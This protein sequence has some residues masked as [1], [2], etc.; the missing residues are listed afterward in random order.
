[1]NQV[2]WVLHGTTA[3]ANGVMAC[4]EMGCNVVALCE[5]GLHTNEF[6][7]ALREKSVNLLTMP[8]WVVDLSLL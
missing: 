8:Q 6:W 3:A 4:I 2:K 7:A 1:M 5:D